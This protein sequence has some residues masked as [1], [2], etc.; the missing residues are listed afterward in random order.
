MQR[1]T[2][3]LLQFAPLLLL[4]TMASQPLKGQGELK[5]SHQYSFLNKQESYF[6]DTTLNDMR[7]YHQLNAAQKDSYG[8]LVLTNLGSARNNLLIPTVGDFWT[9]Q[10]F[11]AFDDYFSSPNTIPYY[12]VRSPLTDARHHNGYDRGQTFSILHTQNINK[13]WNAYIKY[14]RLNSLGF[15]ANNQNKQSSF[16]FSTSY[17]TKNKVYSVRASFAS[18]KMEL[19]EFG[20]IAGDSVFT[21][22]LQ[23][24]RVVINPRL[25]ADNRI[26]YNRDFFVDHKIDL[27]QLFSKKPKKAPVDTTQVDSLGLDSIAPIDTLTLI[28]DKPEV[29]TKRRGAIYLGHTFR[30]N[31]RAQ[32][33]EGNSS[34]YY[35]NYFFNTGSYSDSL[36]YVGVEN[37]LYLESTIGDTSQFELKAGVK[38]LYT[39]SG[40]AYFNLSANNLGLIGKIRGN[41]RDKFELQGSVDFILSGPLAGNFALAGELET[42]IYGK[43]RAFGSYRLQNKTPD[44]LGLYYYSNNFIWN[45]NFSPELSNTITA[46]LKWQKKNY[47]QFKTWTNQNML[48][49]DTESRAQSANLVAY[50]SLELRQDFE[51]WK[52]LHFD[53]RISYQLA[54]DGEEY[55]PLPE[56]VSRNAV[57]VDFKLFK[58]VLGCLLGTELNYYSEFNSPSY[59]PALGRFYIANEYPIGNFPVL[60]LFAQFKLSKAIIFLKIENST[61]GLTPY[62]YFAA[63]HF[64]LNDRVLRFGVNWRFFN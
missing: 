50:S 52:F 7:W 49:Y 59:N 53:N 44:F 14:R 51:F 4:L 56:L 17:L 5:H 40:N 31:R 38:S 30:Y 21:D 36:A 35:A 58:G 34:S 26:L 60:D 8:R 10:G 37:T 12:Q 27:L 32:V 54:L 23:S 18:E 64:P 55:M 45:N 16:T 62:N 11:G 46:G 13:R 24:S 25:T 1:L 3:C 47:L 57:Y 29:E 42:M 41:Y 22:N 63:P 15:Y 28:S 48:Y 20:G 9:Y 6:I 33:Y 61:A 43:L 2:K 19:Q 39:E